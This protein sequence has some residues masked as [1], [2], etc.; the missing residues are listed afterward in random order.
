[1]SAPDNSATHVNTRLDSPKK[2]GYWSSH[3]EIDSVNL[4]RLAW[5]DLA[6]GIRLW[7][8]W[9]RLCINEVKRRYR[10]TLLGPMWVSVSLGIF[11][12]VLAFVWSTLFKQNIPEYLPYLLSGLLPWMMFSSC[13]GEACSAFIAA[14]ATMKSRQF[15]YSTLIHAVVARNAVIF[16]HNLLTYVLVAA[17]CGV[18]VTPATLLVIPGFVILIVNLGWMSMLVAILCL[19]FRDFQQLVTIVLQVV[20][21][22]TPIFWPVSALVGQ[23]AIIV[24]VNF[25]YHLI[26][27]VRSPLLGKA[28]AMQS[29]LLCIAVAGT[30]WLVAYWLLAKKRHR[31]VF[32]F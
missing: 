11:A 17:V 6:D 10:R 30:G 24:D 29:Y 5:R 15:P 8:I 4:R 9:G 16:G 13:I 19:R 21:F 22:I 14:E 1:M 7:D 20:M 25:L 3:I 23:R 26:D 31:L 18:A 32:W 12:I 28:A 27:L 2:Y